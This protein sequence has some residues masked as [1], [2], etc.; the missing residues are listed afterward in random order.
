MYLKEFEIR[1]NDLDANGHLANVSYTAFA[2]H[3]RMAFLI[4]C[5]FNQQILH[6]H[7]LGPVVFYEH[8]YY[9]REVFLGKPVKVS[10]ELS[11][12][13]EDGIFFSFTH[14]FYNHKGSNFA[15]SEMMG[16]WIDL[17]TRKLTGLPQE[18]SNYFDKIERSPSFKVLTKEDTRKYAKKPVDLVMV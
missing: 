10:A 18:I 16:A 15:H 17:K 14:N 11:G 13:S 12:L 5:G 9:F 6:E 4:E 8:M 2:S 3:T 7:K 1:W